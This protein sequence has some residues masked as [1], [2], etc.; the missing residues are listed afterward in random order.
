VS[1]I[2]FLSPGIT[3][4]P[5]GIESRRKIVRILELSMITCEEIFWVDFGMT[6]PDF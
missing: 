3:I 6:I 1:K 2:V 4:S 5:P